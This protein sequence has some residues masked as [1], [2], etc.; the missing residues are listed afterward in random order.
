M[1]IKLEKPEN[2]QNSEAWEQT[3]WQERHSKHAKESAVLEREL[4][5]LVDLKRLD[6]V[7]Y[8]FGYYLKRI[9]SFTKS[10]SEDQTVYQHLLG[11]A[12]DDLRALLEKDSYGLG[13][14]RDRVSLWQHSYREF[15]NF[16][17]KFTDHPVDQYKAPLKKSEK[18]FK[19]KVLA[20][21]L[22]EWVESEVDSIVSIFTAKVIRK[23]L[24]F[25]LAGGEYTAL[26][27]QC[28]F[29]GGVIE[30]DIWLRFK[31]G[32]QVRMH[33]SLKTNYSALGKA[34]AQYPLTFHEITSPDGEFRG[35]MLSEKEALSHFGA[36][37]WEPPVM[38]KNRFFST[39]KIGDIVLLSDNTLGLVLGQSK[40]GAKVLT[41]EGDERRCQAEDFQII[42][43][44]TN[45]T[46]SHTNAGQYLFVESIESKN[47]RVHLTQ[48][49][50]ASVIKEMDLDSSDVSYNKKCEVIRRAGFKKWVIENKNAFTTVALDV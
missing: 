7:D 24:D 42:L 40:A 39:V 31:K 33:L 34:Y 4:K 46:W 5:K 19:V 50:V 13:S 29:R 48:D 23:G 28:N 43:A 32:G 14:G 8:L 6:Y 21:K 44:R 45:P 37:A 35:A 3:H 25:I 22:R 2:Q 49:E 15:A 12:T 47:E 17:C 10:R 36:T 27:D 1:P 16:I 30:A 9:H 18:A 11:K 38:P 26:L 20:K 41:I